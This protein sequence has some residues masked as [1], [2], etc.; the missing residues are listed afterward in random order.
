MNLLKRRLGSPMDKLN[1]GDMPDNLTIINRIIE[2][3]ET[4]RGHV[5]L[6][7][8]SISDQEALSSLKKVHSDWIPGR[9]EVLTEKQNRV[10]QAMSL[11]EEGL[12]NH[13]AYE[14]KV[15][16]PLL[17][18]L[19]MRVIILDHQEVKKEIEQAKSIMADTKLEGLNREKLLAE[20]GR[21]Q[22]VVDGIIQLIEEHATKEENL[23]EMLQRA[24]QQG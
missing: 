10:R 8:D 21:I 23:L 3:H 2:E 15:L 22:Q 24:L 5:K 19:F 17:G 20:E 12:K 18:E 6:V 7:G 1:G 11:L 4:I 14:E 9:L 13:F 16:P